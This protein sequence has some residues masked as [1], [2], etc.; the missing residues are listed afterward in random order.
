MTTLVV[1]VRLTPAPRRALVA[2]LQEATG[3]ARGAC[4]NA[5]AAL[6]DADGLVTAALVD[7]HQ[8]AADRYVERRGK[9]AP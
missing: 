7:L 6:L 9:A 3:A 1:G 5:V 4:G 8:R 2:V